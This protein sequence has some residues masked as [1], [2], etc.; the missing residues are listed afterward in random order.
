MEAAVEKK[1]KEES[2]R[3][4][5]VTKK[6][7]TLNVIQVTPVSYKNIK[8]TKLL[9]KKKGNFFVV[10]RN[11][12]SYICFWGCLAGCKCRCG[13]SQNQLREIDHEKKKVLSNPKTYIC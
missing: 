5:L 13:K 11:T 6:L 9:K 3:L 4:E 2:F 12:E 10:R 7:N 8:F 1:L